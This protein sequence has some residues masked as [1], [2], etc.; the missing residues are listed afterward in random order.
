[1]AKFDHVGDISPALLIEIPAR[2]QVM[3]LVDS[4]RYRDPGVT[5]GRV[6]YEYPNPTGRMPKTLWHYFETLD[7]PG[8]ATVST[9]IVG[10]IRFGR[11]APGES[12]FL[13]SGALMAHEST[14]K[15]DR[16]TLASYDVP[17]GAFTRYLT[18]TR[19]TGP[20]QFAFQTHGN[21][22]SFNLKPGESVRTEMDALLTVTPGAKLAVKVFGG[23][24][25]FPPMHY[26]PLVDVTGPGTVLVHSGRYLL[27]E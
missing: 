13:H 8:S 20:G 5:V 16:I 19:L 10:E 11:L 12:L 2:E 4:V 14:M 22:L 23:A 27:G 26:F 18:A 6:K 24:P 1:V 25:H 9:G 15:Y 17:R 7:G 3:V 21:A